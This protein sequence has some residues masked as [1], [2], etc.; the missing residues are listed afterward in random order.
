MKKHFKAYVT[1][2]P[3]AK[4]LRMALMATETA[5]QVRTITETFI[6]HSATIH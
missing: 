3:G 4:E 2:F 1:D 6:R 5:K